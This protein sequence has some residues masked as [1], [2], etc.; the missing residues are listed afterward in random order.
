LGAI[1]LAQGNYLAG[2][3]RL[4]TGRVPAAAR[5]LSVDALLP[6]D[7]AFARA[8]EEA[9]REQPQ[10]VIG[11]SYRTWMFGSALAVLD[12]SV[13]EPELFYVAALLHDYGIAEVVPEEDFTLRSADRLQ[14]CGTDVGA[15][16]NAVDAAADAITVHATPGIRVETDGALGCY[17]QA[18]AL[19]DLAG[20]RAGELTRD[21]R[22]EVGRRHPRNGVTQAI[23]AMIADEARANPA[24]RFALLRRCG[25]IVLVKQNPLRPR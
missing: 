23:S 19:A 22:A 15:A 2:L 16:P 17:V 21:Y 1:V 18:G 10:H 20:L 13:P 4:A 3:I 11:H 14:R 24:G 6:P 9:C 7:S 8:A 12:G 5:N 25:F